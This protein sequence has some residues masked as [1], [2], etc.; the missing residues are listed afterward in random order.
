MAAS[1]NTLSER[2]ILLVEDEE[3]IRT[4]VLDALRKEGYTVIETHNP[5][6]AA[7]ILGSKLFSVDLLIS[8]VVMPGMNGLEFAKEMRAMQPKLKIILTTGSLEMKQEIEAQPTP[9]Q[10][11]LEKPFTLDAMLAM[12]AKAIL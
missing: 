6:H 12:V 9:N 7:E 4:I 8:D 5:L 11:F 3:T 2:T 10:Y 1:S